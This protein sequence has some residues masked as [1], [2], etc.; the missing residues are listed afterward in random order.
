MGGGQNERERRDV[1]DNRLQVSL[2]DPFGPTPTFR[3]H[4]KRKKKGLLAAE[5]L[6]RFHDFQ[7]YR[8]ASRNLVIDRFIRGE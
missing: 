4:K 1:R 6:T 7:A 3:K 8:T 2:S 5:L